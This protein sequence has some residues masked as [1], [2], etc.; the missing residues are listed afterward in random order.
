MLI[1]TYSTVV[2]AEVYVDVFM[3]RCVDNLAEIEGTIMCEE[4][5]PLPCLLSCH[6]ICQGTMDNRAC[7]GHSFF[8]LKAYFHS[9]T[10]GNACLSSR[11]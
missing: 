9:H 7:P 5:I 11:M 3:Y 10:K 2:A 6:G 8:G 1:V 4:S